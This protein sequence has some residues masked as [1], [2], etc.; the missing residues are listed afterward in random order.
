MLLRFTQS[1]FSLF[2]GGD[3]PELAV[4]QQQ[5]KCSSVPIKSSMSYDLDDEGVGESDRQA[6]NFKG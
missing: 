6:E 3:K 4:T 2:L 1:P 5:A